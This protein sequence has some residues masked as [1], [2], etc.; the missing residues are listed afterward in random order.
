M[1]EKTTKNSENIKGDE[2]SINQETGAITSNYLIS[3]RNVLQELNKV[4]KSMCLAK[5]YNS[6]INLN[7][8]QTQSCYHPAPTQISKVALSSD[9]SA[10]HNTEHKRKQRNKMLKGERPEECQYCWNIEDSGDG[11]HLSDRAYRSADFYSRELL[12]E[13][14]ELGAGGSPS[15]R[16]VEIIFSNKC[17]LKCSYCSPHQSTTWFEE[18]EKSGPFRLEDHTH[19]DLRGLASLGLIPSKAQTLKFT[20]S[21]WTWWPQLYKTLLHFKISGGEPL[22]DENTYK[23]FDYVLLN[24]KKD[25]QL[26][27]ISN[28]NPPKEQWDKFLTQIKIMAKADA[29]DHFMLFFSL[30]SWGPQAEYIRGGL[31]FEAAHENIQQFLS[32]TEKTSVTIVST[33]NVL[34]IVGL[35]KFLQGVLALRKKFSTDRQKIWLDLPQLNSPA[36]MSIKILPKEFASYTSEAVNFVEAN[37]ENSGN[38]FKGF[39][40][41]ELEKIKTLHASI[42]E[43]LLTDRISKDRKDF[44]RFFTEQDRRSNQRMKKIFPEMELFFKQCEEVANLQDGSEN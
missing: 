25:L 10:L 38:R 11:S 27:L 7:T 24:P 9:P 16:I 30:D 43:N 5:W 13:A 34:S 33:V 40:D 26:M 37:L 22:L 32:Q 18:I 28:C 8:G 6:T 44:I 15:P 3:T 1:S 14:V 29:F 4:S 17:N 20:E 42:S 31:N 41:F 21:F 19:N 2:V 35:K 36:W 12:N 39:K 23:V